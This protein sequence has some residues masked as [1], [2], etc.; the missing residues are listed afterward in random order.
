[1][2][3]SKSSIGVIGATG[4]LG[5]EILAVLDK[6]PWRPETVKAYASA[7]STV[8]TVD[9]GDSHLP[10]D[11]LVDA[12][13]EGLDAVILAVPPEIARDAA[14]RAVRHGTRVI[15]CSGA[16]LVDGD[17]PLVIPWVNPEALNELPTR[18]ILAIP[19]ATAILLASVL[20]PLGRAGLLGP[21]EATVMLPASV[22]GRD[23]VDELSRQ[24]IAMFNNGT[25]PR[26]VFE[27]GLAFDLLPAAD[28]VKPDGLTEGEARALDELQRLLPG[29]D[30]G[31]TEVGVPLFSGI[32]ATI[33]IAVSADPA[34][35]AKVLADGGVQVPTGARA[36]PRPRKVDGHP[37]THVGRIRADARGLRLWAVLDNLRGAA[38]VAVGT[39]GVVVRK[40]NG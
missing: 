35:V 39:C 3:G 34:R 26:K 11:D 18:G 12:D 7:K 20:A 8:P 10:V 24:V 13:F 4:A 29:L 9:Y 16:M 30:V 36:L 33:R 1:M 14:E 5:K 31:L 15:D 40:S 28:P 23:G 17:V 22:R 19:H 25:P 6:S 32:A 37:F 27:Q 21:V 2:A 38:A